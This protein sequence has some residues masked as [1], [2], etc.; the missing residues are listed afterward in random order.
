MRHATFAIGLLAALAAAAPDLS[1]AA[2]VATA[3]LPSFPTSANTI[4]RGRRRISTRAAL[5]CRRPFSLPSY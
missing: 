4:W 2:T 3:I 1:R 5:P